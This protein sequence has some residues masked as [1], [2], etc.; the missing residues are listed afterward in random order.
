[1]QP[2]RR[3]GSESHVEVTQRPPHE[4]MVSPV[5]HRTPT[6]EAGLQLDVGL[7]ERRLLEDDEEGDPKSD[8]RAAQRLVLVVV[9]VGG[10]K[11]LQRPIVDTLSERTLKKWLGPSEW[12]H[13]CRT[14]CSDLALC[15]PIML[16]ES[17]RWELSRAR[18]PDDVQARRVAVE[19]IQVEPE[20][21]PVGCDEVDAPWDRRVSDERP[22]LSREA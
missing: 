16:P 14:R 15:E 3:D 5:G 8:A 2:I 20:D 19:C 11:S 18:D 4:D 6:D 9:D 22:K 12:I 7:R 13:R 17:H 10:E 1:M 21:R